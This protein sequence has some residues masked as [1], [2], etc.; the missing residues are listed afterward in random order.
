MDYPPEMEQ[1]LAPIRSRPEYPYLAAEMATIL[2]QKFPKFR[3]HT[4]RLAYELLKANPNDV[5]IAHL[6]Q[7]VLRRAVPG[8]HYTIL[9]DARRNAIYRDALNQ[10]DLEGKTVLEIGTGSGILSILA[11]KAG[12]KHVYACERSFALAQAAKENI[13]RN[14]VADRVTV[15]EKDLKAIQLGTDLPEPAD[16]LLSEIIDNRLLGESVLELTNLAKE[17]LLSD[18]AAFFP[19][20]VGLRG[21]LLEAGPWKPSLQFDDICDLNL[22]AI[23][24]LIQMRQVGGKRPEHEPVVSAPFDLL[25]F[26]LRKE[27]PLEGEVRQ[28]VKINGEGRVHGLRSWIWFRFPTGHFYEVEKGSDDAWA[29]YI[30][31]FDPSI[32]VQDGQNVEIQLGYK[33]NDFWIDI[34]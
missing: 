3:R 2:Y 8:W 31:Q 27:L 22:S 11:A 7:G 20:E 13:S 23:T 15:I 29:T 33:S 28:S 18:N 9:N 19:N 16:I 34:H 6:T 26:D 4:E 21:Q 32:A 10:A 14:G 30:T 17:R 24:P 1:M 5:K 25:Q 12:A